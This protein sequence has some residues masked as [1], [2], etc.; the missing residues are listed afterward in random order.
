MKLS[1][2]LCTLPIVAAFVPAP[3]DFKR[4]TTTLS[5]VSRR[6]A[7]A[8]GSGLIF[9]ALLARPRAAAA[10]SNTFMQEEVNFEPSQQA[11]SDKIDI[12]GAFVVSRCY[13]FNTCR[14]LIWLIKRSYV[15]CKSDMC[16]TWRLI[17]SS[18]LVSSLMLQ[19]RLHP[20]GH[21]KLS[22]ISTKLKDWPKTM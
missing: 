4:S 15:F 16:M 18:Y 13:D 17:T 6:D 5:A 10:T 11:R 3:H 20:T 12:N 7:I 14:V 9:G 2:A 1:L 22:K 21:T 8:T 19:V